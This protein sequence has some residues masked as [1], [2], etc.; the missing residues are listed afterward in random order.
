MREP[1]AQPDR[2]ERLDGAPS[3]LGLLHARV[4]ERQLDVGECRRARDEVEALEDEP[5]L[6]VAHLGELLVIERLDVDTIEEVAAG[7][8]QVEAAEDVHQ[9]ALA[10]A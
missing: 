9:R 8:R 6:P 7:A 3:A 5:D 10:R 4:H 1:G 2:L